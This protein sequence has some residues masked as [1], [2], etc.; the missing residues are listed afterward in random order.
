MEAQERLK[1]LRKTIEHHR[2]LYHVQNISEISPEAL[3]ALKHEL[4]L[5]EEVYPDLV[6]LDSP[7]Q[8]VAGE[9]LKGFKKIKHTVPQWSF[10]D[11]FSPDEMRGFDTRVK[12]MLAK[13]YGRK[14]TPSYVCEL[15]IDGLKVVLM[16]ENGLLVTAATRGDG[17][18]GE[19]VTANV[20]MIESVPL[21][22][23]QKVSGVFE[24]EVWMAKSTLVRLNKE[25]AKAS[26]EPFANPRN[27]AA[28][29]IRQL[30]SSVVKA[31]ALD[32][33]IYDVSAFDREIPKT[34]TKELALLQDLGFKV[35]KHFKECKTIDEV[36]SFW[37]KW[38]KRKDKEDY[39]IDGV[40][41]KVNEKEYQD[42]LGYTGKAPRFGIAFKFPAEQ[43]TTVIEDIVL[44]VGRTG[45][46]TPVAHLRPVSVSG[47]VVSRATLHN[48]DEIARL[49]VRIGDTVI[50]QKAGD[51]IPDIVQVVKEMRNGKEKKFEFPKIVLDTDGTTSAIER[52]PRQAA[53][54]CVNKNM[55]AQ[56]RR[57]FYY[58]VSKKGFNIDGC[59]P[60]VI[61]AL[62][63]AELISNFDDLFTLT[64]GDV[65]SLPRFAELSAKNF[66]EAINNARTATLGKFLTALSIPHVGEE[67]AHDIAQTFGS[68]EKIH[69][70]S[71]EDFNNVY[72]VGE[73][74]AQSLADWFADEH[75]SALLDR[76]LA[77]VKIV[78]PQRKASKGKL[79]G[80][81]FVLTGTLTTLGRD[82]AKEKVRA[83]GGEIAESVSSKTSYVVAGENPGSKYDKAKSL[84][85]PVL[86]EKAFLKMLK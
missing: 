84:G 35:N 14:I 52:I 32:T 29:T 27:L 43:V 53:Y 72:G 24:G 68:I 81:T 73:V 16:Y 15:K 83:L 65:L 80:K 25:E 69:E 78:N 17:T 57:K 79:A 74:V 26:R 45:V 56:K 23:H 21:S 64:I 60:K 75:H 49:D 47:S 5:I 38:Q 37:E 18:V 46:V 31:R 86:D 58:F 12:N 30:D 22:L 55:F 9:P 7:S 77:Q 41:V 8:R 11:A 28:G 34:Q 62:L 63:D 20:K 42:K 36:I 4:V 6:T 50:L 61:D 10:N 1:K 33:F 48:E 54:R 70:A 66:I 51:V 85:V 2:Y 59:G 76:L 71:F 82:E 44:Q 3:D 40:V 13:E 67:T 39:W 19:D